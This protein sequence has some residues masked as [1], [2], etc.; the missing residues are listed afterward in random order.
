MSLMGGA[1]AP[2]PAAK[3]QRQEAKRRRKQGLDTTTFSEARIHYYVL[4]FVYY[5]VLY[6]F[7][8]TFFTMFSLRHLLP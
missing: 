6:Y 8:T 7:N 4:Y 1:L 3:R 5:Y 2:G